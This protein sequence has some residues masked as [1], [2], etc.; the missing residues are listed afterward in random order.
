MTAADTSIV[1]ALTATHYQGTVADTDYPTTVVHQPDFLPAG[2]DTVICN[3]AAVE[4]FL[5]NIADAAE[6][7]PGRSTLIDL[8]DGR[9]IAVSVVEGRQ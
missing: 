4:Y 9:T 2:A 3:A 1:A 8:D 6:D 7:A 5:T